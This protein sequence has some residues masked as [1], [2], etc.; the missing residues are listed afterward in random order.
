MEPTLVVRL[1][2]SHIGGAVRVRFTDGE[3]TVSQ[4]L[5]VDDHCYLAFCHRI[6][7]TNRPDKHGG[8]YQ[9]ATSWLAPL[10]RVV[11]VEPA[12]DGPRPWGLGP[13]TC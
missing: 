2:E 11:H 13:R 3:E 1:L 5:F 10:A 6:I 9:P 8:A 12:T 4:V 7:A